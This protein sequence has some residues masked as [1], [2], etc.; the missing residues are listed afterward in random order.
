M[1]NVRLCSSH[2]ISGTRLLASYIAVS[3]CICF[4]KATTYQS[5]FKNLDLPY[6]NFIYFSSLGKCSSN[7]LDL[8][9]VPTI[10]VETTPK[11]VFK[12]VEKL[13]RDSQKLERHQ[14]CEEREIKRPKCEVKNDVFNVI[15]ENSTA[16]IYQEKS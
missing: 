15:S 10:L 8:H 5:S 16:E 3:W 7:P 11:Q 12:R 1:R 9:Y 4:I 13:K 2:F 14:R 6:N